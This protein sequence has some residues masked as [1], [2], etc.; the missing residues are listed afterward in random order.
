MHTR[1]E[2]LCSCKNTALEHELVFRTATKQPGGEQTLQLPSYANNPIRGVQQNTVNTKFS[3][4]IF[5]QTSPPFRIRR[6][7]VARVVSPKNGKWKNLVITVF[8]G[9]HRMELLE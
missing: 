2:L 9:T 3:I 7:R 8:F 4:S 5:E 6:P 1:T